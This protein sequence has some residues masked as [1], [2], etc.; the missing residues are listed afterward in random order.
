[1]QHGRYLKPHLKKARKAA[2][3]KFQKR[4]AW[5]RDWQEFEIESRIG[6]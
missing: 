4:Q 2:K 1:M 5:L 3:E 6:A